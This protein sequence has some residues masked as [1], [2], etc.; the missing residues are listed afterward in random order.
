[1][2]GY[3]GIQLGSVVTRLGLQKYEKLVSSSEFQN[4]TKIKINHS[5]SR[6]SHGLQINFSRREEIQFSI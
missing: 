6:I 2:T 3:R 5:I 4:V 1:M